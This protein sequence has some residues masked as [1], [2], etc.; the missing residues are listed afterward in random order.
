MI[1]R[2]TVKPRRPRGYGCG[3]KGRDGTTRFYRAATA[4]VMVKDTRF[5]L[6][7]RFVLPEDDT[8]TELDDLLRHIRKTLRIQV[9]V[10]FL[11]RGFDGTPVMAY[12]TRL[13]QPAVMAC[14]LRGKTGGTRSLCQSHCSDRTRYT[15][16]RQQPGEFT[17]NVAVCL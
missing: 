12:L 11:D 9:I 17:A 13:R 8:V 3:V 4:Y 2:M 15:F 1:V 14:T 5:T 10:L 16:C 7:V 6:A